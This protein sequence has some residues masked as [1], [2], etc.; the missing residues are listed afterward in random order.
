MNFILDNS[1][2]LLISRPHTNGH[3]GWASPPCFYSFCPLAYEW[4]PYIFEYVFQ[5]VLL[6]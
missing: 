3:I 4:Q 5:L 2:V 1:L 6:R